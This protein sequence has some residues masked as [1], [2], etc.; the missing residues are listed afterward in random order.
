MYHQ[1]LSGAMVFSLV[2]FLVRDTYMRKQS[3][4]L[5]FM[6]FFISQ[7]LNVLLKT[8]K[9][10]I[11]SVDEEMNSLCS[12]AV[13]L[14]CLVLFFLAKE[15]LSHPLCNDLSRCLF[16]LFLLISDWWQL[17]VLCC[18]FFLILFCLVSCSVLLQLA[19]SDS[20]ELF[21]SAA[22]FNLKQP[23]SF[24]QFNGSV[25]CNSHEDL[26]LQKQFKAVNV[27]GS[28]SSLLKS[29]L[30]SVRPYTNVHLL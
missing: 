4:W 21:W 12:V 18:F 1:F 13:L 11:Y 17:C 3:I 26:K 7:I 24:C 10:T 9:K 22:P 19:F 16:S 28:C 14:S 8:K 23:L 2:S 5:I 27:T 25:C 6:S 20:L 15:S 30:C 29:L